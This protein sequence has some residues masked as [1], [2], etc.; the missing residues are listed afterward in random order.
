MKKILFLLVSLFLLSCIPV[1]LGLGFIAWQVYIGNYSDFEKSRIIDILSKETVLYYA[2]GQSQL[3]SL[4][5]Q[6]HRIYV[7]I[8]Q[9][10][11]VMKDAIVTAEDE[12]FYTNIG[13][14]PKG[15]LRA[16]INNMLFKTRQGASTITQQTVKNLFGRKETDLYVKF[17]EMIN[18]FKLEK[19]YSKNQILEFYL[20]QFHVTG[21]GRGIGVA[22]KYYFNKNVEDLSLIES[23]FIAG[24][25]KG[26]EKYNPFTKTNLAAQEKAQKEAFIRKN[27]VLDR[28]YKSEKIIS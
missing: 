25:V 8:D 19:M 12:D 14:D 7:N 6:E 13:I 5:G 4:F 28:M 23:A 16:I 15:I 24:S 18:A 21:N 3:G 17:Q 10:P 26:P 22:S 2:D 1:C 27:Y 11:N 20:N 9:I